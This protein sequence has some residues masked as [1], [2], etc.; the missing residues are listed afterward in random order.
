K[1]ESICNET[2]VS[3]KKIHSPTPQATSRMAKNSPNSTPD[4]ESGNVRNRIECNRGRKTEL[5]CLLIS[6]YVSIK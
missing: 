5:A 3:N 1:F 6:T 4:N 2:A